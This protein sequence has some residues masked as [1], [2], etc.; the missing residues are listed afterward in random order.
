MDDQVMSHGGGDNGN[1]GNGN[2]GN[3]GNGN[4]GDNGNGK[5]GDGD[6]NRNWTLCSAFWASVRE[7]AL[8]G[9]EWSERFRLLPAAFDALLSRLRPAIGRR[10]SALRRAVPTEVRP[11]LTLWRLGAVT[12]YW[13]LEATF[14]VSRSSVCKILRDVCGAVVAILGRDGEE[15]EEQEEEGEEGLRLH[16][17]R[18]PERSRSLG[19]DWRQML[20]GCCGVPE[21]PREKQRDWGEN[22][23]I[24]TDSGQKSG[25]WGENSQILGGFWAKFAN[26]GGEIP[27]ISGFRAKFTTFGVGFQNSGGLEPEIPTFGGKIP[28][29]GGFWPKLTAL[30]TGIPNPGGKLQEERQEEE[31]PGGKH[32]EKP[33]NVEFWPGEPR[34][35]GGKLGNSAQEV[36]GGRD[37]M[38]GLQ[39][40]PSGAGKFRKPVRKFRKHPDSIG[41]SPNPVGKSPNSI[42][43]F[44]KPPGPVGKSPNPIGKS[45]N[46]IGKFWDP[47]D[48]IGKS[49]IPVGKSPNS[50]GKFWKPLDSMGKSPNTVGKSPNSIGKFRKPPNPRGNPP[51][52][53]LGPA[54]PGFPGI[55][56]FPGFPIPAAA[57]GRVLA[58]LRIP[59][60]APPAGRGYRDNRDDRG[61]AARADTPGHGGCAAAS[62][63]WNSSS[64]EWRRGTQRSSDASSA[65]GDGNMPGIPGILMEIL[66]VW[67]E[68]WQIQG[69][70]LENWGNLVEIWGICWKFGTFG[71]KSGGILEI[72]RIPLEIRGMLLEIWGMLLEI[73]E[74]WL[75]NQ[76]L[77]YIPGTP[78]RIQ[79]IPLEIPAT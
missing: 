40:V 7:E 72:W 66:G 23:Q 13:A 37:C 53:G 62:G 17:P 11:A 36:P 18:D 73:G 2:N 34:E 8:G 19:R 33:K 51:G 3:N 77:L 28:N 6:G 20:A 67:V 35:G 54:I 4:N 63:T 74:I 24:S 12:E 57:A 68:N 25:R 29:P 64:W 15:Q 14:G 21:A 75:K 59:I 52:A 48:P 45:P 56:G 79:E 61:A 1:N 5:N 76:E 31:K 16:L 9:R 50:I 41:K 27:N 30:G 58:R 49:P 47:P 70:L 69:V 78:L 44:G 26:S 46:S 65:R 55:A 10:D 38:G 42:R 22:S 71:W 39:A 60:R 43:K 32:P